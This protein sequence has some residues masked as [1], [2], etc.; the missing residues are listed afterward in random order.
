[1]MFVGAVLISPALAGEVAWG[2]EPPLADRSTSAGV[3]KQLTDDNSALLG[4]HAGTS[5]SEQK[6]HHTP[7]GN[8]KG[9]GG[10]DVTNSTPTPCIG[11]RGE[12]VPCQDA[13]Y[14]TY[15]QD[16]N[17]YAQP[18]VPQPPMTAA[19]WHGHTDGQIIHYYCPEHVGYSD[20]DSW[21]G[22][23]VNAP[24]V[25]VIDPAVLARQA[26]AEM[27]L[28]SITVGISLPANGQQTGLVEAPVWMW[29][30]NP[31]ANTF[32]PITK[33]VTV[34]PVTVT[35][36]GRVD[37]ITWDMGDGSSVTCTTPGTVYDLS[38]GI[39]ASPD[40]GHAYTA[41]KDSYAVRATSYW[42]VTWAGGGQNG[43]IPIQLVSNP[44]QAR[45]GEV[46][47]LIQ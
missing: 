44:V 46:Q 11:E 17:C 10:Q 23:G 14:G 25:V 8:R 37:H 16:N 22:P 39:K 42:V 30:N 32:G 38:F 34:G 7:G 9:G 18:L 45:V 31:T 33:S 28:H 5:G 13:N 2:G 6:T 27:N 20:F 12:V 47:V 40:C 29:V 21:Q 35:A 36:T 1:M 4:V 26:V 43:T 24:P 19:I 15:S 41:A 3:S